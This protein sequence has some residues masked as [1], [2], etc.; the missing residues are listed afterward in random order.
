MKAW[1]NPAARADPSAPEVP[2]TPAPPPRAAVRE[3]KRRSYRR[4]NR[5][6]RRRS[7][8]RGPRDTLQ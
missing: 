4:P 6:W 5:G 8:D 1:S 7:E 2:P 3:V